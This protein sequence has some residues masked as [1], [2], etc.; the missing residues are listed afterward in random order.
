[1]GECF[2][3]FTL[4]YHC[5]DEFHQQHNR[6]D[7]KVC[8]KE[9]HI[10][11]NK[12]SETLIDTNIRQFYF[13]TFNDALM[14]YNK[15]IKNK[16][17]ERVKTFDEYYVNIQKNSY[18]K[19]APKLV[20]ETIIAVGNINNHPD[21]DTLIDIYARYVNDFIKRNKSL[22][23]VGAYLHFDELGVGHLHLDYI[24]VAECSRGMRLQNSLSGAL[25]EL[26]YKDIDIHHT[27]QQQFQHDERDRIKDIC[28]DYDIDICET[29]EQ[30]RKTHYTTEL[31]K[32]IAQFKELE[33][34]NNDLINEYNQNITD[35]D[36]LRFMCQ[37]LENY[38]VNHSEILDII[39]HD[40]YNDY[41]DVM[42]EI[43]DINI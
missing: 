19:H 29:S 27:A 35:F 40:T 36:K 4:S 39:D 2:M 34:K 21:N 3:A 5:G 15:K 30:S 38:F 16:H 17:P 10:D 42:K 6:R 23:V 26:G 28:K 20:Y 24:P 32:L 9:N 33:N 25:R 43:E 12:Y 18:K 8:K 13:N 22:R 31:Y 7:V 1:M 41:L 37:K 11:L 14:E